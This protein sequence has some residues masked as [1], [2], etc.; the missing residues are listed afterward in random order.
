MTH[1]L[2]TL[3]VIAQRNFDG[4]LNDEASP[5]E[6]A[7]VVISRFISKNLTRP[8]PLST[9]LMKTFLLA[10][11]QLHNQTVA[12]IAT[13]TLPL[14]SD[15]PLVEKL[16]Y[17]LEK[18]QRYLKLMLNNYVN[19]KYNDNLHAQADTIFNIGTMNREIIAVLETGLAN[20]F[21]LNDLVKQTRLFPKPSPK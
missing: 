20:D 6:A 21:S 17:T 7:A 1:Y 11:V 16:F 19:R 5:L 15:H 8:T 13:L 4:R 2:A 9:M 10:V 3:I 18:Q 12:R 14:P